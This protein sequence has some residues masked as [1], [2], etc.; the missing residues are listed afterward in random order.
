MGKY[1]ETLLV[2]SMSM[3]SIGITLI[4]TDT[5]IIKGLMVVAVGVGLA[6]FR[7]YLKK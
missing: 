2:F 4:Q 3:I 6:Y 5:N 7:G 1:K